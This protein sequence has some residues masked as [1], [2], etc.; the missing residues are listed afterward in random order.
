MVN[1]KQL[2]DSRQLFDGRYELKTRL[3]GGGFSEVWLAFDTKSRNEVA[4]KVYVQ[5]GNLDDDGLEMFRKE[6]SL[7][8]N[9]NHGNILRPF[10]YEIAENH[11]YLVLP[12][13]P[14]GS[15]CSLVGKMGEDEMWH[16]IENVASGLQY[17]HSY[18][19]KP[20]IHQ[21]IKPGNILI[22]ATGQ[23]IITDFGISIG[24]RNTLSGK[25]AKENSGGGTLSYMAPERFD[26]NNGG[27]VMANDIWSLGAT[28]YELAT[29]DVPFGAFGGMTQCKMH[30]VPAI[31]NNYSSPLKQLIY[32]CLDEQPWNR[33][34]ALDL[35][36]TAKSRSY[37]VKHNHTSK[38]KSTG[39]LFASIIAT[40]IVAGAG[41]TVFQIVKDKREKLI[42]E[43]TN[44][45]IAFE[46]MKK[47][48]SIVERQKHI[49][50][51]QKYGNEVDVDSLKYL[52]DVYDKALEV[53]DCTDSVYDIIS[54]HRKSA[55]VELIQPAY[56]YIV[57][58]E[59]TYRN[60]EV[61]DAAE[62][63]KKRRLKLEPLLNQNN[64]NSNK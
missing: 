61:F 53:P 33:P 2:F 14:K 62:K 29:G 26:R 56:E 50:P 35:F 20:V 48:D 12:Y 64:D 39:V 4:L 16:F 60:A 52:V 27:P 34:S 55:F 3:G 38:T 43:Q 54:S 9:F 19:G 28:L 42:V 11:P 40:A 32:D 8:C 63:F 25:S 45:S 22:D 37:H 49:L 58:K 23:Y 21:D 51:N 31:S 46:N 24:L 15:C 13:C 18:P 1:L 6:F 17:L 47:A 57:N 7:V 30:V 36:E 44:N 59:N 5:A 10:L 41:I